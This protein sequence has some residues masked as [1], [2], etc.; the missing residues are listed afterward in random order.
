MTLPPPKH[1][2]R[3][4]RIGDIRGGKVHARWIEWSRDRGLHFGHFYN[5]ELSSSP[6]RYAHSSLV[7]LSTKAKTVS[8]EIW[9]R[10]AVSSTWS[11]CP[12]PSLASLS[13]TLYAAAYIKAKACKAFFRSSLEH[14]R[15]QP[16][17]PN[18]WALRGQPR[19][20]RTISAMGAV[21]RNHHRTKE[22]CLPSGS[23][24]AGLQPRET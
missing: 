17:S 13:S 3:C 24:F 19:N 16:V 14:L 7:P 1:S 21:R 11:Q 9:C 20:T 12:S 2:E 23:K 6:A 4:C 22:P 10:L 5:A 8:F 15:S 18:V